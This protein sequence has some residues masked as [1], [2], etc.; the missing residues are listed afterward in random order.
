MINI[1]VLEFKKIADEGKV[2][3]ER[4]DKNEVVHTAT[5]KHHRVLQNIISRR[6]S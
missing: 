6:C 4:I 2:T 3:F 1:L 5:G